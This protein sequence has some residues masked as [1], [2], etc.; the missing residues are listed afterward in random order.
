MLSGENDRAIDMLNELIDSCD[1]NAWM[2]S[3]DPRFD[4]L[5]S[6]PRYPALLKRAGFVMP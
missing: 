1:E 2:I 6:D 4:P 3:I 5:R